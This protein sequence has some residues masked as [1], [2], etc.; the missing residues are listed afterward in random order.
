MTIKVVKAAAKHSA[1]EICPWM[2]NIPPE[3]KK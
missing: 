2:I 3:G 1:R